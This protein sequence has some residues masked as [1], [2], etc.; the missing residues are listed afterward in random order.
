[1]PG[2]LTELIIYR[3]KQHWDIKC[4]SVPWQWKMAL[5]IVGA[6]LPTTILL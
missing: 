3:T 5:K 4:T 6:V 1:M 2:A